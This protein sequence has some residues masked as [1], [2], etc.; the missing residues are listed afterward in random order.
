MKEDKAPKIKKI[1]VEIKGKE[2]ALTLEE[3]HGLREELERLTK[4]ESVFIPYNQPYY[5]PTV[6]LW[7]SSPFWYS[8]T[9]GGTA[10]LTTSN[11]G[12]TI[13]KGCSVN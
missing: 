11:L 10:S 8:T 12:T 13:S 2:I 3:A 7:P 1:I 6:P 5:T 4:K 9:T